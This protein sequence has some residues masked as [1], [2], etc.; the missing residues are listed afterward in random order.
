[1]H[2]PTNFDQYKRF[3]NKA[4]LYARAWMRLKANC[5]RM[6]L[7]GIASAWGIPT[8]AEAKDYGITREDA[9]KEAARI[10]GA[11]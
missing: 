9:E 4:G 3:W 11:L 8:N 10:R 5:E 2:R 6:T 1:M 7:F